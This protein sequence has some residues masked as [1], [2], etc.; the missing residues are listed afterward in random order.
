MRAIEDCTF[1]HLCHFLFV[2]LTTSE[3]VEVCCTVASKVYLYFL[4]I[5]SFVLNLLYFTNF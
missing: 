5:M 1:L 2:C 3:V 4:T